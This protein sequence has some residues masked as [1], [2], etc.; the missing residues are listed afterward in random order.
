MLIWTANCVICDANRATTFAI[1]D[2]ILFLSRN[3]VNARQYKATGAIK[4]KQ[5]TETSISQKYQHKRKISIQILDLE[6]QH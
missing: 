4:I 6:Q 5:S 2:T 3:S 1:T